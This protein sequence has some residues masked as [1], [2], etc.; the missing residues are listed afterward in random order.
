MTDGVIHS[1]L[2]CVLPAASMTRMTLLTYI[3]LVSVV[4]NLVSI[5]KLSHKGQ[6]DITLIDRQLKRFAV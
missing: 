1:A 3:S 2:H 5:I 6:D 4:C